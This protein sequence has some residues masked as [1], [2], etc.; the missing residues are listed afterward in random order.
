MELS[1]LSAWCDQ[2]TARLAALEKGTA[3]DAGKA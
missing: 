2:V 3:D 1:D